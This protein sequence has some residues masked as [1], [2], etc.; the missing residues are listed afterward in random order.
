MSRNSWYQDGLK[1]ECQ[2]SGNCCVSRGQYGFVYLTKTD[3]QQMAHHLGISTLQFTKQ[4][5]A[6]TDGFFHLKDNGKNP[7]CLFL[8]EN[9]CSIYRA[10]PTQCR[11]WPFWPETLTA[12][13][14]KTEVLAFCPGANKGRLYSAQEIKKHR[15]Q[16]MRSEKDMINERTSS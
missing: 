13:A 3:R 5:C 8:K 4:Y 1:F 7:E 10:R 2:G 6:K 15:D 16:Q 11:T 12:K 9:R 14:W